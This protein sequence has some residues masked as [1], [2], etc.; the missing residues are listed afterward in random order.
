MPGLIDNHWHRRFV[1]TSPAEAMASDPGYVGLG[2]GAE[3]GDTLMRGFTTVRD[4]GGP[5]FGLK[6]DRRPPYLPSG[7]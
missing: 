1:R 7:P 2:A 4:L 3:A 5:I 6:R